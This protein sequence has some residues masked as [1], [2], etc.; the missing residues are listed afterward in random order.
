MDPSLVSRNVMHNFIPSHLL[1]KSTPGQMQLRDV[2]ITVTVCCVT[3]LSVSFSF[4]HLFLKFAP[5]VYALRQVFVSGAT[6][7][8]ITT[9]GK[10]LGFTQ[11]ELQWPLNVFSYVLRSSMAEKS[12]VKLIA[13][14]LRRSQAL[15]WLS[16]LTLREAS[17]HNRE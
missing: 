4:G 8:S 11:S 6:T 16:P 7:V 17:G 5:R 10:D 3:V 9:I 13:F 14:S 15:L 2:L 12:T 1:T